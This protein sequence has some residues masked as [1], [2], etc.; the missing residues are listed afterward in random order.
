[1]TSMNPTLTT[2]RPAATDAGS[3][4]LARSLRSDFISMSTIRSTKIVAVLATA[5]SAVGA[6]SLVQFGEAE[7]ADSS[8][9]VSGVLGVTVLLTMLLSVVA[10]VLTFTTDAQHGSL[11][12]QVTAQPSR[13][14][15]AASRTIS[16]GILGAT[17]ALLA[18]VAGFAGAM[19]GGAELVSL[20]NVVSSAGWTIALCA[21]GAVL[22][23]GV[24]MIVRH[25]SLAITGVLAWW[26]VVENILS[27]VL[28][29]SISRYLPF[30]AGLSVTYEVSESGLS[31]G[32]SLAIFGGYALAALAIGFALFNRRDIA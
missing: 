15:L 9:E 31:S 10:G 19:V 30:N 21:A 17:F 18:Y 5:I 25:S 27:A 28:D 24:G 20:A 6:W 26:L 29:A 32:A 2:T 22:G 12:A 16:A 14:V 13:L 23:L 1:M 3:A 7:I 11:A 4:A 8:F